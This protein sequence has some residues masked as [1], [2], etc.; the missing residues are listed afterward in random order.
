[1]K[2][3]P[4]GHDEFLDHED[5]PA[6]YLGEGLNVVRVNAGETALEFAA[7]GGDVTGPASS[8]DSTIARFDGTDGKTLNDSG[9]IVDEYD[10]IFVTN[11]AFFEAHNTDNYSVIFRA[12]NTGSGPREIARLQGAADSYFAMGGS[13]QFKF[14]NSGIA[15]LG[16][17]AL[18]NVN[19]D[20]GDIADGVTINDAKLAG[21]T[22][23]AD[24]TGTNTCDTPGGAG[25]DTTAI[26]VNVAMAEN[27]AIVLD[28]AL[29][30]DGKYCVTMAKTGTAGEILDF[31]ES[32][33]FKAGDSKWWLARG[34]AE[35]T[36][37][38]MTGLVIV[39]GAA[40]AA[41]TIAIMG[42]VRADSLY[43]ALTVGAPVFIDPDTPGQ[44]STIELTTGEYQK[45]IGWAPTANSVLLTGNPDWV[46]IS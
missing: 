15:D 29:S 19:I 37:S 4:P 25:T 35:A 41:V 2:V 8:V 17:G 32:V 30:V 38:P 7:G 40:E 42:E 14:Y 9:I 1:M 33:Y 21:I 12:R 11:G 10:L 31:G 46:K 43:P 27:E 18:T 23:G 36:I 24:V 13:Q 5:T 16:N 28:A 22:A 45:C 6:S 34:N 20:S 26:H 44:V 3:K 39:A